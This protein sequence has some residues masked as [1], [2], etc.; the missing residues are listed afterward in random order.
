MASVTPQQWQSLIY[1]KPSEFKHPDGLQ[2]SIL[3]ALDR[4]I[5]IIG[6]RPIILSDYRPGDPRYHGQ[7]LAIDTTWP[8]RDPLEI[9]NAA[10]DSGLFTGLGIYIN[11]LNIA[12]FHF[13]TRPRDDGTPAQWGGVITHPLDAS[14]GYHVRQTYYVTA[15]EVIEI[16]KKKGTVLLIGFC[17]LGLLI[18]LNTR[19]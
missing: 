16:I 9:W 6:S 15:M 13:D 3:S 18:Y 10:I 17:V 2:Y 1:L 14:T 11:E 7:G 19:R 5:S 4:F 12:S 8:G